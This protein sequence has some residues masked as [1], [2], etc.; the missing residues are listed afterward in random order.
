MVA[1]S[2]IVRVYTSSTRTIEILF[3]GSW[4][5]ENNENAQYISHR[6]YHCDYFDPIVH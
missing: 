1:L 5:L 4:S 2:S 3:L 6:Y